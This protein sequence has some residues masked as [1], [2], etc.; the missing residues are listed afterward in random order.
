VDGKDGIGS[1]IASTGSVALS[2]RVDFTGRDRFESRPTIG[3]IL[4]S[5]NEIKSSPFRCVLESLSQLPVS[6][7]SSTA[8]TDSTPKVGLSVA[9]L[10]LFFF[11]LRGKT[12]P[13]SPP[14][15]AGSGLVVN[16]LFFWLTVEG[17]GVG[18]GVGRTGEEGLEELTGSVKH[19]S[20][21]IGLFP[22]FVP[23]DP[24]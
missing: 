23:D 10:F 3:V 13:S 8:K 24:I 18:I 22:V 16:T 5:A 11:V 1:P 14:A 15:L 21:S 19:P 17:R 6:S 4:F 20:R 2:G 7:D 9:E 12:N